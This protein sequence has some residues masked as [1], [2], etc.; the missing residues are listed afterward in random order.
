MRIKTIRHSDCVEVGKDH[1]DEVVTKFLEKIG[2]PNVVSVTTFNY[3]HMDL[4]T[5][6]WVTDYGVLV[7]YR[8]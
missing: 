7:I 1:F 2:E 5:R 8:G 6:D 4:A 3:T